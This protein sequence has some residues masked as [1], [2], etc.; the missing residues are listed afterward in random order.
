MILKSKFNAKNKI[1]AIGALDVPVLKH[2]FGIINW[3]LEE[4]G[5]IDW[6][7]RNVLTIYKMHQPKVDIDRLY[8]KR[9]EEEEA[10]YKLK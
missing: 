3:R 1:S 8:V 5:K 9:K 7:T 6:K 10:C 4:I 2:S